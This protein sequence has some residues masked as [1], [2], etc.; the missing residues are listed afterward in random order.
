[1]ELGFKLCSEERSARDLV[2]DAWRAEEA[3]FGFVAASDHFHPWLDAEGEAPSAWPVLGA[4]GVR[5]TAIGLGTF[6]TCPTTRYHPTFV[7]QAAATVAALSPGR[8]FL[9]LG[10]G[11]WLNE[12]VVGGSWPDPD[13]RRAGL[14]EAIEIIRRLWTGEETTWH[15]E[16]LR[17]DHAR[18]YSLPTVPPPI[19]VAASGEAAASLAANRGDGMISTAPDA[20][21]VSAY[22]GQ[23]GH[24]PV[25][26]EMSVCVADSA[27]EAWRTVRSRWPLPGLPPDASTDLATPKDFAA[28]SR[29]ADEGAIRAAIPVG[30]DAG[31]VLEQAMRYR[32]AGFTH[33]VVHQVG[34]DP[35]PF[36]DRVAPELLAELQRP[37]IAAAHSG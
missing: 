11:E 24:G 27:D 4:I 21:L 31:P 33:L 17:V 22:R 16:H 32:D 18:L 36:L 14:A 3:G 30:P 15:G 23:G 12:H 34:T 5:T 7:A 29:R 25:I 37:A 10:T 6:V 26:G 1:M 19:Y 2:A 28:A 8:M 13:V 9:G 35:S 20:E